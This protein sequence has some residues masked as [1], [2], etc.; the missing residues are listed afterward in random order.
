MVGINDDGKTKIVVLVFVVFI[1]SGNPETV[2]KTSGHD[3]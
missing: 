1:M 3:S 2:R